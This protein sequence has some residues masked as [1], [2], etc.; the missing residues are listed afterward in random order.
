METKAI[1]EG[2]R[3][4]VANKWK[5]ITIESDAASVINHIRGKYFYRRI[6]ISVKYA[7][8]LA[9]EIDTLSHGELSHDQLINM[10]I[11]YAD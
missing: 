6:D 3:L 4:E 11:E 8:Y 7:L 10:R 9:R 2:I 5:D 1:I